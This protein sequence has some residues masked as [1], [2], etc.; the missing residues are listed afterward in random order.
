MCLM[1]A[2]LLP[3]A[4]EEGTFVSL[5]CFL[6][7]AS[8]WILNLIYSCVLYALKLGCTTCKHVCMCACVWCSVRKHVVSLLWFPPLS[9]LSATCGNKL[10]DYV[11]KSHFPEN[12][13]LL[14]DR[15]LNLQLCSLCIKLYAWVCAC[16]HASGVL[17][18]SM[19]SL[20]CGFLPYPGWLQRVEIS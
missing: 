17:S 16:V 18:G 9:W 7:V 6:K 15:V 4:P 8:W 2:S 5:L 13:I 11:R 12:Y 19:W 1:S 14:S 20:S 10:I 3:L